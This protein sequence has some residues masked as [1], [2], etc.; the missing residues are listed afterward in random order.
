MLPF[1]EGPT[2][3]P[4]LDEGLNPGEIIGEQHQVDGVRYVD[5]RFQ[6]LQKIG[7]GGFGSVYRCADLRIDNGQKLTDPTP[8]ESS[9]KQVAIKHIR[10]PPG[11]K[12]ELHEIRALARLEHK[13]V[14]G[15]IT[16]FTLDDSHRLR[17]DQVI[18]MP[19]LKGESLDKWMQQRTEPLAPKDL[20]DLWQKIA[21]GASALHARGWVHRDLKPSNI[22]NGE[23]HGLKI[24]DLGLARP[25]VRERSL[26]QHRGAESIPDTPWGGTPGY[27]HPQEWLDLLRPS[28]EQLARPISFRGDLFALGVIFY[29][30]AVGRTAHPLSI[31]QAYECPQ[32]CAVSQGGEQPTW[33]DWQALRTRFQESLAAGGGYAPIPKSRIKDDWLRARCDDLIQRAL[34][35]PPGKS[36]ATAKAPFRD[37][38]ELHQAIGQLIDD[39]QR[40]KRSQVVVR[41]AALT[42]GLLATTLLLWRTHLDIVDHAHER[43]TACRLTKQALRSTQS[44]EQLDEAIRH[45]DDRLKAK[46]SVIAIQLQW[47]QNALDWRLR[48]AEKALGKHPDRVDYVAQSTQHGGRILLRYPD[49]H[50]ALVTELWDRSTSQRIRTLTTAPK[51]SS[52]PQPANITAAAFAAGQPRLATWSNEGETNGTVALWDASTGDFLGWLHAAVGPYAETLDKNAGTS[53]GGTVAQVFFSAVGSWIFIR[54]ETDHVWLWNPRLGL[55][56][57][58]DVHFPVKAIGLTPDGSTLVMVGEG[59]QVQRLQV[60]AEVLQ[61]A[62]PCA[63]Q[64]AVTLTQLA[65][66]FDGRRLAV[67]SERS[68]WIFNESTP[69]SSAA[70]CPARRLLEAPTAPARQ[71]PV[72][73]LPS[74]HALAFLPDASAIL[75]SQDGQ[76][77]LWNLQGPPAPVEILEEAH[78]SP[79]QQ[80][81]IAAGFWIIASDKRVELRRAGERAGLSLSLSSIPIETTP[82]RPDRDWR[83]L[84]LPVTSAAKTDQDLYVHE[85]GGWLRLSLSKTDAELLAG[86]NLEALHQPTTSG[87]DDCQDIELDDN[88]AACLRLACRYLSG[89][90]QSAS[91]CQAALGRLKPQADHST[92]DRFGCMARI[93]ASL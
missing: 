21:D 2:V 18:V 55:Q 42:T 86:C 9:F 83:G 19:Y 34:D 16:W 81:V 63:V 44:L 46:A 62:P 41:W 90:S 66:S 22:H 56:P 72:R 11:D 30:L 3:P 77:R 36:R 6:I 59:G 38:T 37:A 64:P 52:A 24:L 61:S 69:S 10:C 60:H 74:V 29:Q 40:H 26:A 89:S 68:A 7:K 15:V 57:Y 84:L 12:L 80:I 70:L 31:G 28:S 93:G 58:R 85:R 82:E 23:E 48:R 47:I 20:L 54:T 8:G 25:I 13:H 88:A 78:T 51:H 87:A 4:G 33:I 27:I 45:I 91:T 75:V 1:Y 17:G 43:D 14:V 50:G 49:E 39:Y 76:V 5:R 71:P 35:C 79:I 92:L 32:E 65:F 53:L 73:R 67:A